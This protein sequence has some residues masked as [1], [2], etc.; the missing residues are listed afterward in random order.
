M[1]RDETYDTYDVIVVGSGGG[2][3]IGAYTAA[4]RGLKTLCI[5]KTDVVGGTT[6]YSGA[7]LWFPGAA[8]IDRADA[9]NDVEAARRYLRAVVDDQDR[10]RLQDA[11]LSTG[12]RLIDELEQNP[13]FGEFTHQ[14]V[15][16]YFHDA[17]DASPA[18]HT[19]FP[20]D[21]PAEELGDLAG[22]VRTTIY[23]E[24]FGHD[25]GPVL[26]GGRALIGRALAAFLAT[27]HGTVA[28]KTA[29]ESL[30]VEDGKVVG[31]T[32][33]Q[34]GR[35]LRIRAR[36]G[37]LLAAGGFERSKELRDEHQRLGLTGEWSNGGPGNTGDA[38]LAG[39]AAGADT[40]L[41]DEAWFVPGV[42]QP[43]GLP[44]FHSGTRSGIW[45]NAEGERFVNETAP[46]DQVGH[47]MARLHRDTGVDH[48]SCHWVFDQAHADRDGF[49]GPPEEGI[50]PSWL[51]SGAVRRAETLE[52][53]A[54]IIGVPAKALTATVDEFN[55]Y[56]ST[57]V[58][59]KFQRGQSPWDQMYFHIVGF[60]ARNPLNYMGKPSPHLTN[61]L[62]MPLEKPP[63]YAARIVL[64][65]I[66]TKGGLRIDEHARVLRH[67]GSPIEGLYA[68]GNT[69]AP[70]SGRV[71]PG[72]GTPIG[73]SMV[74]GH[75]AALGMAD[76]V[77]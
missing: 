52:E 26:S 3:L 8:P 60:P 31:V 9:E 74:F 53:L 56:A 47:V 45:V 51:E 15:P 65:D 35:Q 13:H 40:Q 58:D 21:V 67:D 14:P 39:L 70:M 42:V 76:E 43:D 20:R 55:G 16:D 64:G 22:W 25:P 48:T 10:E 29:L 2:G 63:Y 41:L 61:P 33:A 69:A 72:A 32:A 27:G 68:A 7:G 62:L 59:E 11:Y 23:G 54:Q 73:S 12:A 34:D 37:V 77:H 50:Q 24:R 5:E 46:Y 18:G 66:G 4:A 6:A 38:L 75:R 49:G 36:R 19:V 28:R 44:I 57:G 71:Y 17:P 1:G 30:I